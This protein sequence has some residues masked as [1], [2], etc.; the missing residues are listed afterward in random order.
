MQKLTIKYMKI[1]LG[2]NSISNVVSVSCI[3]D[4]F[5]KLYTHSE[6]QHALIIWYEYT[7]KSNMKALKYVHSKIFLIANL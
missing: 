3:A 2:K 6:L 1:Q 5:F 7:H 4:I